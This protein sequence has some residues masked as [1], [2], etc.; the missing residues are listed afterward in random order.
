MPYTPKDNSLWFIFGTHKTWD[1]PMC[2]KCKKPVDRLISICKRGNGGYMK[3]QCHG[4]DGEV[5]LDMT[6]PD[7]IAAAFRYGRAFKEQDEE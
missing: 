2:H 1:A 7:P 4:E 5:P 3:V 6:D